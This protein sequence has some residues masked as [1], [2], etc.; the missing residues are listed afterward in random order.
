MY[1][2]SALEDYAGLIN[3][4]RGETSV[5]QDGYLNLV[6]HQPF[7]VVGAIIPWNVPIIIFTSKVGAALATGNTVVLKSSE[8]APLTSIKLASLIKEAG[9][10]PGV[11]NILAGYGLPSGKAIAEHMDI[12]KISFTG[13]LR[14]GRLIQEMS[15]RSN[16][17]NVTLHS[18]E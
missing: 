5:T 7:G 10:P 15:A 9:F 12:R 17:K 11:V 1:A 16:L 8:K 2:V 4:N 13:S 3:Y 18:M 6:I 14:T